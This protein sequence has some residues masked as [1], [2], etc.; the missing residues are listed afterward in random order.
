ME[1]YCRN[2]KF[3]KEEDEGETGEVRK[4]HSFGNGDTRILLRGI[5][6]LPF[7]IKLRIKNDIILA[8]RGV[9]LGG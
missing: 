5:F 9:L 3:K 6:C 2:G 1:I 8:H 7:E 4:M